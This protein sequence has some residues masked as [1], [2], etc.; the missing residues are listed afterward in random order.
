MQ[1][2]IAAQSEIWLDIGEVADISQAEVTYDHSGRMT[3]S[4]LLKQSDFRSLNPDTNQVCV[5][6]LD[7]LGQ[8]GIDRI[9]VS[10]E[11]GDRRVLLTTVRDLRTETVLIM[12]QAIGTL[13]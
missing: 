4:Q 5:V 1:A 13:E 10:F 11:I 12:R 7:P 8:I 6:Q 3:S 9:T 2:A